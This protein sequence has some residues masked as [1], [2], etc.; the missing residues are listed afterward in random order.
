MFLSLINFD[1]LFWSTSNVDYCIYI[2]INIQ[3]IYIGVVSSEEAKEAVSPLLKIG[4]EDNRYYKNK[5]AQIWLNMILKV[6]CF[7]KVRL[8]NSDTHRGSYS[9]C[10]PP[11]GPLTFY[12]DPEAMPP[13]R[14]I[15]IRS[16]MIGCDWFLPTLVFVW[17]LKN[18][19]ID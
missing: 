1:S 19:V 9:G 15:W 14:Y 10:L 6:T 11:F 18:A 7:Y 16:V 13:L 5:T 2:F 17:A 4:W 3:Y 12:R 8:S